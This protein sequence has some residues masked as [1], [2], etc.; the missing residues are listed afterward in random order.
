MDPDEIEGDP[1]EESLAAIQAAVQQPANDAAADVQMEAAAATLAGQMQSL[2][3]GKDFVE[4]LAPRIHQLLA[5]ADGA[6]RSALARATLGMALARLLAHC[7]FFCSEEFQ[8]VADTAASLLSSESNVS[9]LQACRLLCEA[10]DPADDSDTEQE[11]EEETGATRRGVLSQMTPSL[12]AMADAIPEEGVG[13]AAVVGAHAALATVKILTA[14]DN[15]EEEGVEDENVDQQQLNQGLAAD[16][17]IALP[18]A[19]AAPDGADNDEH[20]D[21]VDARA[22]GHDDGH[23]GAGEAGIARHLASVLIRVAKAGAG[24]GDSNVAAFGPACDG[25]FHLISSWRTESEADHIRSL[26]LREGV[27][28]SISS[29]LTSPGKAEVGAQV[30]ALAEAGEPDVACAIPAIDAALLLLIFLCKDAPQDVFD[31]HFAGVALSALVSTYRHHRHHAGDYEFVEQTVKEISD[32]HG[33]A[34][35]NAGGGDI[36]FYC[37]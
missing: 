28:N 3:D 33:E 30:F 12:L 35:A 9:K 24:D 25:L 6:G 2:H 10:A 20:G 21:P 16:D 32:A 31:N 22:P 37:C 26:A 29:F 19:A 36:E 8:P 18:A 17:A 13:E 1:I 15:P 7:W 5:A 4:D 34:W 14:S 27:V 23:G 11:P